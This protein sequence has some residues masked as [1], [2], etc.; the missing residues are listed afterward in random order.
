MSTE[1]VYEGKTFPSIKSFCD[2]F[3]LD[4]IRFCRWRRLGYSID[5]IIEKE[6]LKG[7]IVYKGVEYETLYEACKKLKLNYDTVYGRVYRG[8]SVEVALR[9]G[10]NK[11]AI[12]VTF[13]GKKF[14]SL[15]ECCNYY[16]VTYPTVVAKLARGISLEEALKGESINSIPIVYNGM[17]F[18]SIR[19]CANYYG[20]PYS[21][22]RWRL[23]R[24]LSLEEAC[25]E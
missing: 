11:K 19:E 2:V 17:K 15:K 7:P 4:Y 12:P 18:K 21:S 5:S 10:A 25:A 22:V 13:K 24:G 6:R 16:E 14:K 23:A 20:L 9:L 1:I 3:N 8:M